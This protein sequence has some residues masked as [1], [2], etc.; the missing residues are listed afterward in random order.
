[1]ERVWW[2]FLTV[3]FQE[4]SR[5]RKATA[6]PTEKPSLFQILKNLGGG[7]LK[8]NAKAGF[9]WRGAARLAV[10]G[11]GA[12]LRHFAGNRFELRCKNEPKL[13]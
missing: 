7:N 3:C 9:F 1:M 8:N 11:S 12:E 2:L 13:Y 6:H 4:I 10:L 5:C